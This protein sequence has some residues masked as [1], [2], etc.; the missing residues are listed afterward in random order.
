MKRTT[1]NY[2]VYGETGAFALKI[3]INYRMIK[4]N[5]KKKKKKTDELYACKCFKKIVF[6]Y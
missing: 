6:V 5:K 2:V 4:K 1:P 3:E